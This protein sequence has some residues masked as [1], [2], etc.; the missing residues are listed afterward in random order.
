MISIFTCGYGN[1]FVKLQVSCCNADVS[2]GNG[3]F[4]KQMLAQ[5]W[6]AKSFSKCSYPPYHSNSFVLNGSRYSRMD[7]VKFVEESLKNLRRKISP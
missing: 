4:I 1:M 2:G 5:I 7:Q 6:L 3:N